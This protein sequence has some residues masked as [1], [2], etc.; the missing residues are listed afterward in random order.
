MSI[1][2]LLAEAREWRG[3][4]LD[5]AALAIA[6]TFAVLAMAA[7]SQA[8]ASAFFTGK[9]I[10]SV[11]PFFALSIGLTAYAKAS[12]AENLIARAF[13]GRPAAFLPPAR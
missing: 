9:A 10:W 6:L 5:P 12:G 1:Q 7:P 4:R 2:A 8:A 3:M 11:L 13:S